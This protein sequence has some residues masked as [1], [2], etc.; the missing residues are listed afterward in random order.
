[1]AALL[2]ALKARITA[3]NIVF[4]A[5]SNMPAENLSGEVDIAD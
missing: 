2:T 4:M 1:V 5:G 3:R